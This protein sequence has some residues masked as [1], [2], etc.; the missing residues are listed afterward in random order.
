MTWLTLRQF[1]I[2]AGVIGALLAVLVLYLA[3]T[4]SGLADDYASG[5]VTCKATGSCG[6]FTNHFLDEH[7][8]YFIALIIFVTALP[9]VIGVFWGAPLISREIEAGTHR[10]VWSQSVTR[11]RWM[12]V[13]LGIVGFCAMAAGGIACWAVAWW[14]GPLDKAAQ[15]K[16]IFPRLTPI[17]FD[18]RGIAAIGYAA[19][20]FALGVLIGV[21]LRRVVP[22]MAVTL[23]VF[24]AVQLAMPLLV[25]PHLI[26]PKHSTVAVTAS[27]V[28]EL[29]LGNGDSLTI[30]VEPN[31]PG[32]W[33]LS[34]QT[35][36]SSGNSVG[37]MHGAWTRTACNPKEPKPGERPPGP[38]QS[39]F[40]AMR[41]HGYR[42]VLT[43][44]PA[45]RFWKFQWIETGLFVLLAL[46]MSGIAF[47]R[48]RRRSV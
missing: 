2:Q 27:N 9:G 42:Q 44:Q 10:L 36:D 20:A 33:S 29:M 40:D 35:V 16:G 23:A 26:P 31:D 18:A 28:T 13:K 3:L 47:S 17:M 11:T 41:A 7:T 14:S 15:A 12:A 30:G 48:V 24:V 32:A 37:S 45:D 19:F 5:L 38:P 4:R 8:A 46:G 1:R 34:S 6:H 21:L 39:C 22:A 25:R 43:Y